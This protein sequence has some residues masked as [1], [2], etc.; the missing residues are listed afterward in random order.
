M[1]AQ[2]EVAHSSGLLMGPEGAATYAA[3]AQ[4]VA[5]GRVSKNEQAVLFNCGTGLK[6]PMPPANAVLDRTKPIDYST[7]MASES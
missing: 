4:S 3:Y 7:L 6:Y 2:L 5:S 1:A